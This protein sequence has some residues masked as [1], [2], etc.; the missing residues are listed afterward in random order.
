MDW[1][2]KEVKIVLSLL[3]AVNTETVKKSVEIL[4]QGLL[5]IFVVVCIVIAVTYLLKYVVTKVAESKKAKE[6][7]V[8]STKNDD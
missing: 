6:E 2:Y 8:N 7:V 4:W 3:L 5:A 1:F